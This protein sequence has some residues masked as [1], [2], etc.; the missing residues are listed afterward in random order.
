MP[1]G[2]GHQLLAYD[3]AWLYQPYLAFLAALLALTLYSVLGAGDPAR[4]RCGPLAAFV[5]AQ[6]ALLFGY[7]LW[8]GIKELVGGAAARADR[9]AAALALRGDAAGAGRAAPG[10]G[11]RGAGLRAQPA[12][13]R[14]AR[15]APCSRRDRRACAGPGRSLLTAGAFAAGLAVLAIPALRRGGRLAA[16][17]RRLRQARRTSAT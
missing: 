1:L 12:R 5:A 8:G 14:L 7:A 16:A 11:L 3:L 15:P 10:R 17:H 6:P 9:R 4:G 2:I 13:S